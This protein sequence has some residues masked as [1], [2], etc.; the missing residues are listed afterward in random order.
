MLLYCFIRGVSAYFFSFFNAG[1]FRANLGNDAE[2]RLDFLPLPPKKQEMRKLKNEELNR[3]SVE[4]FKKTEKRPL[5]IVLDNIRSLNNIGS[6]FR[7]A[8]AFCI[9]SIYLCGITATP[10]HRD[11]HKTALGATE[12]VHWEYYNSTEEAV[13]KLRQNNYRIVAVEQ[14]DQ[15]ILLHHFQPGKSEKLGLV[16][17]NE[18]QGVNEKIV[19]ISDDCL[20]IPQFGTKHSFN[21]SVSAGIVL[22]DIYLKM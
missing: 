12:S 14:T 7:T 2:F 21:V 17:G 8:D 3:L 22:W 5:I 15:S 18:V 4:D 10:P 9:E 19:E 13:Q 1:K 16:F 20:E 6:I 11:I